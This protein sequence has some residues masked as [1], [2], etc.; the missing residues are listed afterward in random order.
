MLKQTSDF[1]LI[2]VFP[3]SQ[4]NLN[5]RVVYDGL[6]NVVIFVFTP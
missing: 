3:F 5:V 1:Y 6:E 2:F 4:L